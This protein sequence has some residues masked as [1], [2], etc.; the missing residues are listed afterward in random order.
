MFPQSLLSW[1]WH[2]PDDMSKLMTPSIYMLFRVLKN[3]KLTA[4]LSSHDDLLEV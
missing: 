4:T 3:R 2:T 1:A